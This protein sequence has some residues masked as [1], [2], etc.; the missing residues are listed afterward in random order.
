MNCLLLKLYLKFRKN[1]SEPQT[2]IEPATFWS[3]VR[4]CSNHWATIR[5]SGLEFRNEKGK[6]SLTFR[7][8]RP[9]C[10]APRPVWILHC[11]QLLFLRGHILE[12][13]PNHTERLRQYSQR[14]FESMKLD[15]YI[16]YIT[17]MQQPCTALKTSFLTRSGDCQ[18]A[19]IVTIIIDN[20]NWSSPNENL[21]NIYI[22]QM[23]LKISD[24]QFKY[25]DDGRPL[26]DFCIFWRHCGQQAGHATLNLSTGL[27][28][29][30]VHSS[31]TFSEFVNISLY[32]YQQFTIKFFSV[33]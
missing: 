30:S 16:S 23:N 22:E 11:A 33:V 5:L 8:S 20:P 27:W 18:M 31:E 32:K 21:T 15:Y 2:G 6:T 29:L 3:P 4:V 10:R 13:K 24:I 7:A 14:P 25:C 12:L 28:F 1:V 17:E 9:V 26:I 19:N